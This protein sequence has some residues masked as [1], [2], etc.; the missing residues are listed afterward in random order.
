VNSK[1]QYDKKQLPQV[2]AMG[3]LS[4]GLFGYFGWRM[5]APPATQAAPQPVAKPAAALPGGQ[6]TP[7]ASA[8]AT[9]P[10]ATG[11]APAPLASPGAIATVGSNT[12]QTVASAPTGDM[13]DPFAVPAG[14][15]AKS[16]T[17]VVAPP[18][19][20]VMPTAMQGPP[21]P[22]LP[23]IQPLQLGSLPPA[24]PAVSVAAPPAAPAWQVTGVIVGDSDP[25]DHIAILRDGDQRRYVRP[26][27]MVDGEFRVES[28]DQDGVTLTRG[29]ERFRLTLGGNPAATKHVP[30]PSGASTTGIS[31]NQNNPK[32]ESTGIRHMLSAGLLTTTE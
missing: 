22:T 30:I 9:A 28:V 19:P 5:M 25:A 32:T 7:D 31:S 15:P 13:R 27:Q 21:M 24:L 14:A 16:V 12:Q 6:A 23:S 20:H 17:T 29:S 1:F 8:S 26:G 11:A 4:V 18:L 10:T 3:I 2:I